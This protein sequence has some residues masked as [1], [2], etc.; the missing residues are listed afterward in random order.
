MLQIRTILEF[1]PPHLIK[2]HEKQGEWKKVAI[3]NLGDD[4]TDHY[5]SWFLKKRFNIEL[6][7]PM[8]GSHITV[9]NDKV[10]DLTKYEEGKKIFNNKEIVF[11]FDPAELRGGTNPKGEFFWWLKVYNT[12]IEAIREFAGFTRKPFFNLHLTLGTVKQFTQEVFD[13][14]GKPIKDDKGNRITQLRP[15]EEQIDQLH[16]EYILRQILKHNL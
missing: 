7:N 3:C 8:R 5:Y 10:Y 6:I 16:N 11:D 13:D 12:D 15:K 1:D 2:K 4:D 14:K 9:I